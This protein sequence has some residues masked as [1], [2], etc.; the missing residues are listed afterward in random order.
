[1][2]YVYRSLCAPLSSCT[3]Q[4]VVMVLLC[5]LQLADEKGFKFMEISAKSGH[6]VRLVS[7]P[8]NYFI[9]FYA[10]SRATEAYCNWPICLSVT[11]ISRRSLK[12]KR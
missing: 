3:L 7:H 9:N 2:Y 8:Q 5:H 11:S 6:N 4:L 12:T 1:M 10:E